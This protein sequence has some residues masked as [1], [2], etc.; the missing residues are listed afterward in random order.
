MGIDLWIAIAVMSFLAALA[1]VIVA[2][3]LYSD[4][5]CPLVSK[6]ADSSNSGGGILAWG[7]R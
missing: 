6:I 2:T 7:I 4:T 1:A 3:R 5:G